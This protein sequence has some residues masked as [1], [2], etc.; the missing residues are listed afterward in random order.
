MQTEKR[1]PFE[2]KTSYHLTNYHQLALLFLRFP[3]AF[4]LS[5]VFQLQLFGNNLPDMSAVCISGLFTLSL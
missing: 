1:H 3:Q 4:C 5:S 2:R